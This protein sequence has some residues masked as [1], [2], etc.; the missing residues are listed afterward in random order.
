MCH[1]SIFSSK[2]LP[3]QLMG[4]P[5]IN[6][7][8]ITTVKKTMAFKLLSYY[9]CFIIIPSYFFLWVLTTLYYDLSREIQIC[10]EN[11]PPYC[12][13]Q[14]MHYY[15]GRS[16]CLLKHQTILFKPFE[17]TPYIKVIKLRDS[18]LHKKCLI[19]KKNSLKQEV[20]AISSYGQAAQI[21]RGSQNYKLISQPNPH[22]SS[23]HALM[24]LLLQVLLLR[25]RLGKSLAPYSFYGPLFLSLYFLA[26]ETTPGL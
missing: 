6:T 23:N 24:Q 15:N 16:P 8:L 11:I 18:L 10:Y 14:A 3:Q 22:I 9:L 17:H 1:C 4:Y 2:V 25:N 7:C 12:T 26:V 20:R 5:R 21:K 19:N 13:D